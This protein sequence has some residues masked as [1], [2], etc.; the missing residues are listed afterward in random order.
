MRLGRDACRSDNSNNEEN[1]LDAVALLAEAMFREIGDT[2]ADWF[3]GRE[4]AHVLAEM[5]DS[6]IKQRI[7]EA[8]AKLKQEKK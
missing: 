7:E 3:R 2:N 4:G 6:L 8:L 5:I 1:P